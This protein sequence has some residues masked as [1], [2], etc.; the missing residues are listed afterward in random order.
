MVHLAFELSGTSEKE[1]GHVPVP[2]VVASSSLFLSFISYLLP[3]LEVFLNLA[4]VAPVSVSFFPGI[5]LRV[6]LPALPPAL[7]LPP[8]PP[9]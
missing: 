9:S 4:L 6:R 2:S 1:E 3:L 8:H 7:T 5:C